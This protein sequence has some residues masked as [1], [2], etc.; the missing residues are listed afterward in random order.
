MLFLLLNAQS[1]R[2]CESG[3][4]N[5]LGNEKL[6]TRWMQCLLFPASSSAVVWER[7]DGERQ[8]QVDLKKHICQGGQLIHAT[9]FAHQGLLFL[10]VSV[11]PC[12][13][14]GE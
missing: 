10:L 3:C 6:H 13:I 2:K 4:F 5:L 7:G 12:P 1:A 9:M 14:M 11:I 8:R